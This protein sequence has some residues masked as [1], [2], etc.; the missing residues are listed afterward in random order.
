MET[1]WIPGVNNAGG[2]GRWA[3]VEL[4][5]IYQIEA[6]FQVKL[7]TEFNKI[8]GTAGGAEAGSSHG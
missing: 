8:I 1:Y 7:E 4:T 3:F 5:E 2:Y 6:A